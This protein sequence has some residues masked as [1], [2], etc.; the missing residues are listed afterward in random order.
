MEKFVIKGEYITL[1]QF[2]KASNLV[3]SG[4]MVK[5]FLEDNLILLNNQEE[6]R[7]GKKIYAGDKLQV[8]GKLYMFVN[9]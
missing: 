2:I 1:G 7:R 8:V 5:P 6:N 4:G 9:D 3:S